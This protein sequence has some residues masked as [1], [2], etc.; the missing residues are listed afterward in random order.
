MEKQNRTGSPS[1]HSAY[2]QKTLIVKDKLPLLVLY[3]YAD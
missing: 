3:P 2:E 1:S